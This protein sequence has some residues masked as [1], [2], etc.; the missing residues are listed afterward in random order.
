MNWI[1]CLILATEL[2]VWIIA[3]IAGFRVSF[4]CCLFA[5]GVLVF[6]F[7]WCEPHDATLFGTVHEGGLVL[8]LGC[9]T[10]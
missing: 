1:S 2:L 7:F 6:G 4:R 5:A 8:V 3:L 10:A 9:S